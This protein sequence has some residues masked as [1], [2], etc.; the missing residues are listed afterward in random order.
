MITYVFDKRQHSIFLHFQDILIN[1]Y[2]YWL[3]S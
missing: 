2:E 3:K 1:F